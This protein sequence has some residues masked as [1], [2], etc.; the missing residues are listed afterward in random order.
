MKKKETSNPAQIFDK[1]DAHERRRIRELTKGHLPNKILAVTTK[2][3][4]FQVPKK[5]LMAFNFDDILLLKS[6]PP[7]YSP[8][9]SALR[10]RH[11]T[12]R[13]IEPSATLLAFGFPLNLWRHDPVPNM[14]RLLSLPDFLKRTCFYFSA[15]F[16]AKCPNFNKW[17]EHF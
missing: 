4:L 5:K 1:R 7:V 14:E 15:L 8:W 9:F 10:F 17:H 2:R 6:T 12:F 11:V 13:C 16:L 3:W